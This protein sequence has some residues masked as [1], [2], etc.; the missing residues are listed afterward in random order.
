M[1][2]FP[3]PP[4][5]L[6]SFPSLFSSLVPSFIPPAVKAGT[7]GLGERRCPR[8]EGELQLT[9]IHQPE[10]RAGEQ[11]EER[12]CCSSGLGAGKDFP[13]LEPGLSWATVAL[14]LC[15]LCVCSVLW[16]LRG[17]LGFTSLAPLRF[18]LGLKKITRIPGFGWL[19]CHVVTSCRCPGAGEVL[20]GSQPF[21]EEPRA[22]PAFGAAGRVTQGHL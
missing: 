14:T 10:R 16:R 15:G 2:S 18:S 13:Q 6:S 1:G 19:V 11:Q 7:W 21:R 12:E 9:G 22:F 3:C 4:S 8:G 20:K 17:S 5:F